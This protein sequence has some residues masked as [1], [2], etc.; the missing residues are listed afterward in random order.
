[1]NKK[2]VLSTG[3]LRIR[4][5]V[6]IVIVLIVFYL[7]FIGPFS[8]VSVCRICGA[9]KISTKLFGI[10]HDTEK[11]T[12]LSAFVTEKHIAGE[13]NHIWLFGQGSGGGVMCAIGEGRH[14]FWTIDNKGVVS[15]LD[16]VNTYDGKEQAR[17]YLERF[18]NPDRMLDAREF[19]LSKEEEIEL[20][21]KEKFDK[22]LSGKEKAYKEDRATSFSLNI[23]DQK[24]DFAFSDQDVVNAI[25]SLDIKKDLTYVILTPRASNYTY[26]KCRGDPK[27][28]FTLEYWDGDRNYHYKAKRHFNTDEII[29]IFNQYRNDNSSWKSVS[30]WERVKTE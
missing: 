1:M 22:W 30:D 12:P 24:H 13:H 20:N 17:A 10:E 7:I 29:K 14:L 25:N 18:L 28:G 2:A 15:F 11:T 16:L 6:L 8:S 23:S 4:I 26:I 21:S 9:E 5:I 27:A 19:S 3:K